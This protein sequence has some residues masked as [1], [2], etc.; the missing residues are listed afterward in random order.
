[1]KKSVAEQKSLINWK[2]SKP[3][4]NAVN[5]TKNGD[6]STD[7]PIIIQTWANVNTHF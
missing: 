3:K 5:T 4:K 7:A 2:V 1:M 6:F